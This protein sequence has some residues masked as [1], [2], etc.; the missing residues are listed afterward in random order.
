VIAWFVNKSEFSIIFFVFDF[1]ERKSIR[2]STAVKS[3][4]T[5]RRMKERSNHKR[6]TLRK[7]YRQMTQE[8]RLREAKQT[9]IEN[10]KSL[11]MHSHIDLCCQCL[12]CKALF[13]VGQFQELELEKKKVRSVK[14]T[15]TGPTIKYISTTTP[16]VT[17]VKQDDQP[18]DDALENI[19]L[20]E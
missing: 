11:S 1:V 16:D 12:C 15:F 2:K 5:L 6:R 18:G 3:A 20:D 7:K 19:L 9:E 17:P 13:F 14:K 10:L 4:E 8:E